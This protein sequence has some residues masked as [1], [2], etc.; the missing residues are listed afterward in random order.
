MNC[1]Y[2]FQDFDSS[3]RSEVIRK[4]RVK[5]AKASSEKRKR[6]GSKS[7]PAPRIQ[8]D[9][10]FALRAKGL[11]LRAIGKELKCSFNRVHKI[12]GAK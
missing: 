5:N 7:G 6:N 8:K 3:K 2:C 4:I 11:S 9:K 1:P 10:V 12:V